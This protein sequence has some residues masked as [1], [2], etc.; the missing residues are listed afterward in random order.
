[1]IKVTTTGALERMKD[2]VIVTLTRPQRFPPLR[3]RPTLEMKLRLFCVSVLS[4]FAG[5]RGSCTGGLVR[6][7]V[8]SMQR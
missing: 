8:W 3:S 2:H 4:T 5:L 7:R 1:M 6:R